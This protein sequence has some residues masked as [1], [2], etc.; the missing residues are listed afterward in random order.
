MPPPKITRQMV[1]TI[2]INW[3]HQNWKVNCRI[4]KLNL[5]VY[6][7]LLFICSTCYSSEQLSLRDK[8]I[9]C[10]WKWSH[11]LT[12]ITFIADHQN[13]ESKHDWSPPDLPFQFPHYLILFI[14][15]SPWN[16]LMALF[17]KVLFLSCKFTAV[18]YFMYMQ[19]T[20]L[21]L[22]ALFSPNTL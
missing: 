15:L 21:P 10:H 6:I 16:L 5:N 17:T 3:W 13:T 12:K 20:I 22:I 7:Y 14:I 8:W 19:S 2:K 4:M 11:I 18:I 1:V 9:H